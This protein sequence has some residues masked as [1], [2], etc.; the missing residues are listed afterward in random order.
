[1]WGKIC[2][3]LAIA[4]CG[5]KRTRVWVL[6]LSKLFQLPALGWVIYQFICF[7][8]RDNSMKLFNCVGG[9]HHNLHVVQGSTI[10]PKLTLGETENLTW[11]LEEAMATYSST[12]AWKITWTEEP[13]GLQS[14]GLLQVGHNW[15]TSL[16]LSRTGEGN[17]NPLQCSFFFSTPVF[18]SGE[19]QGQRS[20]W[21]A[22][23][24][25]A[26]SRTW[27]KRLSS[28]MKTSSLSKRIPFSPL[29]TP[30]I[31]GSNFFFTGW[32]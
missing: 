31:P 21:A 20:L 26:Q 6:I 9:W 23:Y 10:P 5:I 16:S 17:G 2:I 27:L 24:G 19:F 3:W 15:A 28:N 8:S 1:M 18:L 13:D 7:W 29:H 14:M 12:L 30:K 4:I 11:K 32:F 22:V 25:V